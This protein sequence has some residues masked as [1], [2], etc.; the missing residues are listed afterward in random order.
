MTF[1]VGPKQIMGCS[2]G[3]IGTGMLIFGH[4]EGRSF[5]GH[6]CGLEGVRES[7]M[8]GKCSGVKVRLA[9]GWG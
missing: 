3:K 8:N 4:L 5:L 9:S 1:W 6:F 7:L 2:D